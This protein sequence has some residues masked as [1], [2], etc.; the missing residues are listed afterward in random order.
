MDNEMITTPET[1]EAAAPAPVAAQ[2]KQ[3]SSF[4]YAVGA[5][6]AFF[7]I[8]SK[9]HRASKKRAKLVGDIVTYI[10]LLF[11]TFL[12]VYPFWWMLAGSFAY[13]QTGAERGRCC[14]LHMEHRD[15][16]PP[17]F[18]FRCGH[19]RRFCLSVLLVASRG[20]DIYVGY[21]RRRANSL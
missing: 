21:R 13:T 19:P 16:F 18:L 11:G 5:I 17:H 3:Y 6:L 9:T 2:T 15:V 14:P 20:G 7:G 4:R 1:E 8:S 12:M 10:V